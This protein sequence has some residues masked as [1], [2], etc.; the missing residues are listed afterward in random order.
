MFTP[1]REQL[2]AAKLEYEPAGQTAHKAPTYGEYDPAAQATQ[3]APDKE[4]PALQV[5]EGE[6]GWLE[7]PVGQA[8]QV[9]EPEVEKVLAGQGWLMP[10]AR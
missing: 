10:E 9:L 1:H 3:E 5:H 4:Y 2:E 8:R 6:P 7:E